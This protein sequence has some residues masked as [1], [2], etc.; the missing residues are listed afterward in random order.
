MACI[1]CKAYLWQ[2]GWRVI[3]RYRILQAEFNSTLE[4]KREKHK[5]FV[6]SAQP[7]S[8]TFV[9]MHVQ[10][11]LYALEN[12]IHSVN[13]LLSKNYLRAKY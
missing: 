2:L 11:S 7:D 10:Y 6:S 12:A 3:L 1:F 5:Y 13:C 4:N 8:V 9:K